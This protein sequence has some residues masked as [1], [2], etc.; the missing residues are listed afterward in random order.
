VTVPSRRTIRAGLLALLIVGLQ[1]ALIGFASAQLGPPPPTPVPPDGSL[2]PFPETLHTPADPLETPSISAASAVLA[3]LSSGQVLYAKAPRE[4]RSIASLTKIMTAI[5]TLERT[6]P[7]DVVTVRPDAVIPDLGGVAALGLHAGERITVAHL[8]DALML[9]SANDAAIA[10]A[11]QVSGTEARFVRLMNRSA[12]RLGM[13]RTRFRS[14]NGLDDRG[15][16]TAEDLATLTR[17]AYRVEG[18]APLVAQMHATVP[19]PDGPPRELQ[20][21]NAMLWLYPGAVGVK[22]GYT[23]AAGYCVVAVA[24]REGRRLVAVVLGAP[25]DAFSDAAELLNHGFGAFQEHTFVEA[26]EPSGVVSMRGGAV[27]VETGGRLVALVPTASLEDVRTSVE[28]DPSAAYPPAPGERVAT[29]V[30][31]IPGVSLGSV[32][33]VVSAVPPPPPPPDGTWWARA[34]S[35]LVRGIGAAVSAISG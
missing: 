32:P 29:L 16:S 35:A 2:S 26:G 8:L 24:E 11:D 22:T 5:L 20:N 23:A 25:G 18:F 33:L 34:A 19:A 17:A 14:P 12:D 13:R 9:Q 10:L 21:R 31:T 30:V 3:E 27:P 6:A 1:V 28:V 7:D 15:T 4:R